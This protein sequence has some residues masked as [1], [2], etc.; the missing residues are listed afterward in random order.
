MLCRL[1]ESLERK[2]GGSFELI[3]PKGAKI[4]SSN[5]EEG[6]RM[7]MTV[8]GRILAGKAGCN[9]VVP[10]KIVTADVGQ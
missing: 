10:G 8:V 7:G 1:L 9:K 4:R 6:I 5:N 3:Y 2:R